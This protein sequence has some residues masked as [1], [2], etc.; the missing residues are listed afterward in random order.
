MYLS[1]AM[2]LIARRQPF[3]GEAKPRRSDAAMTGL[4]LLNEVDTRAWA[5]LRLFNTTAYIKCTAL[6]DL[7]CGGVYMDIEGNRST[8]HEQR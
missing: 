2:E 3:Y 1:T 7:D 6:R 8:L 4:S 5:V